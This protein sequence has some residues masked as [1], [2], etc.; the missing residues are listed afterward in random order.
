MLNKKHLKAD[1]AAL[2][3]LGLSVYLALALLSYDPA[4][5]LLGSQTLRTFVGI[6]WS[7]RLT[8]RRPTWPARW[9]RWWHI[10]CSPP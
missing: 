5:P 1:L 2:A 3:L 8:S 9:E 6:S 7:I 4:D 10:C